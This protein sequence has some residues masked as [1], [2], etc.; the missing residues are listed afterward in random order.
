MTNRP[1][2]VQLDGTGFLFGS[3]LEFLNDRTI[4]ETVR[5]VSREFMHSIE[6]TQKRDFVGFTFG[7]FPLHWTNLHVVQERVDLR[8]GNARAELRLAN[9]PTVMDILDD[10]EWDFWCAEHPRARSIAFAGDADDFGLFIDCLSQRSPSLDNLEHLLL[11]CCGMLTAWDLD[12]CPSLGA[13]SQIR[14]LTVDATPPQPGLID[15]L[16]SLKHLE[17]ITWIY[18]FE[19]E[20][21]DP[22]YS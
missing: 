4:F 2:S 5:L 19:T 13:F 16:S 21:E 11:C 15:E 17:D 6:L 1:S 14:C 12:D 18:Q 22:Y 7:E 3:V 8:L 9:I 10:E 20:D